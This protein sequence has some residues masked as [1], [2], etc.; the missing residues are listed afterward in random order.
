MKL[1]FYKQLCYTGTGTDSTVHF[2]EFDVRP[3]PRKFVSY[4]L[5]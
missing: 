5:K 4:D 3:M 2:K 1:F